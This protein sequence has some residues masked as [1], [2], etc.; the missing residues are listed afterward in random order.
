MFQS[1]LSVAEEFKR[2]DNLEYARQALDKA[3]TIYPDSIS[4]ASQRFAIAATELLREADFLGAMSIDDQEQTEITALVQDGF[5]LLQLPLA[6][7]ERSELLTQLG[8]LLT[9]DSTWADS[10]WSHSGAADELFAEAVQLTPSRAEALFWYGHQLLASDN[11]ET[12][13]EHIQ[14]AIKLAPN[15]PL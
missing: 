11:P 15:N 5:R 1:Y 8:R 3:L 14:R 2:L 6:R 4:V 13:F 10:A 7:A 12:G 9:Y